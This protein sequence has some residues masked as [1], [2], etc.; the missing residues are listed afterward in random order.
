MPAP[1]SMSES[2]EQAAHGEDRPALRSR[3]V[4]ILFSG[5]YRRPDGLAAFLQRAGFDVTMVDN[6]RASGNAQHDL[7]DEAFYTQLLDQVAQGAFFAI[8]AAPP[9]STFS[10]SRFIVA[11]S[12]TDGGPPPVRTR[13]CIRGVEETPAFNIN[14]VRNTLPARVQARSQRS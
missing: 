7:L 11:E 4:L 8:F 5:P 13:D 14:T 10:I 1:A 12:A 3:R 2:F 6:D 9:C